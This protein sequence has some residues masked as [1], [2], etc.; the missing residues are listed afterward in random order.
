MGKKYKIG[1]I[2]F[3]YLKHLQ[4]P[5]YSTIIGINTPLCQLTQIQMNANVARRLEQIALSNPMKAM[6]K[7]ESAA[8][9]E[10]AILRGSVSPI[11]CASPVDDVLKFLGTSADQ[12]LSA[13]RTAF[14]IPELQTYMKPSVHFSVD[15]HGCIT[16]IS[17]R[18]MQRIA[19]DLATP[20]SNVVFAS[21]SGATNMVFSVIVQ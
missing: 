17:R 8:R 13:D 3:F 19:K 4:S 7:L 15:R 21:L 5:D 10:L 12:V 6:H 16:H 20:E 14:A 11:R 18:G 9:V 1:G 2:R